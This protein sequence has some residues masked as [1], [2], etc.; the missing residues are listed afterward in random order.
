[1]KLQDSDNLNAAPSDR[2]YKL[3]DGQG[4]YVLVQASGSKLWRLKY[5]CRGVERKLSLGQYPCTSIADA[6]QK[7]DEARAMVVEGQD[8][9]AMKRQAELEAKICQA[10]TFELVAEEYIQKM[11]LEGRSAR[12][13]S[14]RPAG[15]CGCS[16][17]GSAIARSMRSR[18]TSFL[19]R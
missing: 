14:R 3:A 16:L 10:T 11:E 7:R 13:P 19:Q 12:Q 9:I 1:M 18:P 5:H 15:S 2:P 17:C 8:P 4:L 6:R